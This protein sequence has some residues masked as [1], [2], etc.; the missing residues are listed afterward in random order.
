MGGAANGMGGFNGPDAGND[1]SQKGAPPA[2]RT[3]MKSLPRV[4]VTAYDIAANESPECSVCLDELVIGETA[5]R[6][7]CGHL[8]H[9]DCIQGWLKKSNECPV[10]RWELPTDDVEYEKGRVMRMSSR[11]IRLR[12]TD[13]SVKTAQELRRLAHFIAVDVT[14]C[15]EKSE[16]VDK[17]AQSPQVQIIAAE[18]EA[19]HPGSP[20]RASSS[21]ASRPKFSREQLEA[22]GISD[23]KA[24]MERIGVDTSS[25]A[26]QAELVTK[27][28]NSDRVEVIESAQKLQAD[29]E[30]TEANPPVTAGPS[31]AQSGPPLASRSIGQLRQ[32]AREMGVSLDGCLEKADIVERIVLAS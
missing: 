29:V 21:S 25:C 11:K 9:E 4:K 6:V 30:M 16:L 14:G 13:L 5:L 8:Y 18:S 28:M 12:R 1:P 19:S 17:I 10:C 2:A 32:L 26:E 22:M 7:P 24:I 27:L 15:L 20:S 31:A 23:L 3:T